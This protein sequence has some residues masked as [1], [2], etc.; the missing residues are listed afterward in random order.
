MIVLWTLL[1][2]N[3]TTFHEPPL[4]HT[5]R[6]IAS[7]FKIVFYLLVHYTFVP[8]ISEELITKRWSFCFL[9]NSVTKEKFWY[10][11][12]LLPQKFANNL[13]TMSKILLNR[14]DC[15]FKVSY[16]NVDL[17]NIFFRGCEG[18]FWLEAKYFHR[19]PEL[20]SYA[21]LKGLTLF[22]MPFDAL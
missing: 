19:N 5:D 13:K 16:L 15:V 10:E 21:L 2:S 12:R 14:S 6:W 3:L 4:L 17:V 9:W 1:E 11:H 22:Y 8:R 20:T 7:I 18:C